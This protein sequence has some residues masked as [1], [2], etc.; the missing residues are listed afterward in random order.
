MFIPQRVACLLFVL[1]LAGCFGGDHPAR[2]SRTPVEGVVTLDGAPLTDAVIIFQPQDHSHAAF[3]QTGSDGRF[4]LTTFE[5]GDGAVPGTFK[6]SF[7]KYER[8]PEG[9]P[10]R[11]D[12]PTVGSPKLLIPAL[13]ASPE[14]SGK[15]VVIVDGQQ[16]QV[17]F[18]LDGKP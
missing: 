2:P 12:A 14:T 17:N 6:V 13:Y 11:D 9:Q 1:P 15:E 16:E 10:V 4:E 18:E 8:P 3:G 5:K 7:V